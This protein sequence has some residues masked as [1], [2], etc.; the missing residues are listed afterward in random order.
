MSDARADA[1]RIEVV[2]ADITGLDLD[3]IVNA[4]NEA[5]A[6]GGGVCGAIH[7]A[8]GPK[9]AEACRELAPCPTG[10]AR[11][12]PGFDLKAR[13]VIHA[14]GPVW[15]GGGAG[16]EGLL[17]GCYRSALEEARKIGARSIAFPAISTGVYG[18]PVEQAAP[19]AARA[20]LEAWPR[21]PALQRVIFACF[22]EADRAAYSGA[23]QRI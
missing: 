1:R 7:R 17:A 9:L 21:C 4:A 18:F 11:T 16:E 20:V 2:Q 13:W 19:V 8:A 5:L 15:R 3:A 10:E 22:S 6:R 12:T 14:V 23:V